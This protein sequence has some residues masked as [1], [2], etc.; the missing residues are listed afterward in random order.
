MKQASVNQILNEAM[1]IL[2][3]LLHIG[4]ALSVFA[5][6]YYVALTGSDDNPGT[7]EKSFATI[8]RAQ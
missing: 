3:T 2:P 4:L 1:K 5:Q 8:Q 6:P 7:L